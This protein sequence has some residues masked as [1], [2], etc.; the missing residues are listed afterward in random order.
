LP[1]VAGAETPNLPLAIPT[2][3]PSQTNS[4]KASKVTIV[5]NSTGNL[6]LHCVAAIMLGPLRLSTDKSTSVPTKT[7]RNGRIYVK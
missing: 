7:F 1:V 4:N 2:R 3:V 6:L 5:N